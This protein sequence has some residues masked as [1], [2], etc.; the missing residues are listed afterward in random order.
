MTDQQPI[1]LHI[2]HPDEIDGDPAR[3]ARIA[4][5]QLDAIVGAL[6]PVIEATGRQVRNAVLD[7]LSDG[8]DDEKAIGQRLLDWEAGAHGRRLAT[9]EAVGARLPDLV[10]RLDRIV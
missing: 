7:E 5:D 2:Q 8:E 3:V 4:L 6:G 1:T 10:A 9:V